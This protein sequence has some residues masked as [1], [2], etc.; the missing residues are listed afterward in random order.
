M[1]KIIVREV[2]TDD[3]EAFIAAMQKSRNFHH[4]WVKAPN[5]LKDFDEFILRSKQPTQK[6]FLVTDVQANII[7][8]F[9]ISEIVRGLFQNAYLGFYVTADYA[10]KG[11]MSAGLKLGAVD[12]SRLTH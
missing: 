3:K 1:K 5:S 8:V 12:N 7:G 2:K 4:P 11:Y 6:S 9:N 10:S